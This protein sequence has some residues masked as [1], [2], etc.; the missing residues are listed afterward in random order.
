VATQTLDQ[1]RKLQFSVKKE[2]A[3]YVS[4]IIPSY[5]Y[6]QGMA[7]PPVLPE[8]VSGFEGY[9]RTRDRVLLSAPRYEG[10]WASALGIAIS[11]M[12]SLAWEVESDGPR[13]REQAQRMLL[14]MGAGMGVFGWVP[15]LS[16]HLRSY[17]AIG[18]AFWEIE[19]ATP[20]NGSKVIN[21]HHLNP[22]RCRMTGNNQKPVNY[23]AGDGKVRELGW[24]QVMILGDMFDPTEGEDGIAMSATERAYKQIIKLSAIETYVYEKVSGRRPLALYFLGGAIQR[25]IDDA[26]D[27]AAQDADRRNQMSYMGATVAAMPGD[28]PLNLVTIPLAELPDGF[29]ATQERERADLVYAN[30]IG[31]DPQDLNP[32]LV[33]RQ[34]LGSTGNQSVVLAEKSE[35]RPLS[36]W[37]QQFTHNINELA[38][39]DKVTFTFQDVVTLRDKKLDAE[40]AKL[41]A[42]TRKLQVESGEITPDQARNLAVD[43][44]DLPREFIEQDVTGGGKLTDV[45]KPEADEPQEDEQ[46]PMAT[47]AFLESFLPTD[48]AR[49]E[50]ETLGVTVFGTNSNIAQERKNAAKEWRGLY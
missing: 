31:L 41:R 24:H 48:K 43:K 21:V 2:D 37:R 34:G 3:Q 49:E 16:M 28:I 7:L 40:A 39:S 29:D 15:A 13:L 23:L 26:I 33:G 30:A 1:Q 11:K 32:S 19:R 5:W 22:L 20:A 4:F 42:E 12:A 9:Y 38:L 10:Q 44:G 45:D 35:G 17:L 6:S 36:L 27:T 18:R 25:H 46:Q 8:P 14:N 47:K 50:L